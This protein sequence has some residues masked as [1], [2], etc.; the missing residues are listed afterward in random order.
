MAQDEQEKPKD[1]P[2]TET[3]AS[4]YLIDNQT[5][6]IQYPKTLEFIIQ[7]KF[8]AIENGKTDVWGI[9]S[10]ANVRLALDYS[11]LENLQVGYGLTKTDMV[12]DV[13]VKYNILQQT[14]K[15]TIPVTVGFYGNMG[16]NGAPEDTASGLNTE[17]KH[18][19][20]LFGQLIISR[21]FNDRISLQAG[22]SFSHF[23]QTNR[24]FYNFDRVGLH[25]NGR[26]KLTSLGSFI[27]NYDQPLKAFQIT[28]MKGV[29]INPNVSFGWEIATVS[30]AFQIYMGYSK[31]ILPQYYMVRENSD[32]AFDQF[33]IGF[34]MTRLWNF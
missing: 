4:G 13:N 18:R 14:R 26:I 28:E 31:E 32:F 10:S 22:A 6:T 5:T 21:K 7:H 16:I 23:N 17:F 29:D 3:F 33:R 25:F 19:M 24:D 8:G 30:H 27:F 1:K 2:V 15:N 9:Y 11:V 12:H 34:T 20:S